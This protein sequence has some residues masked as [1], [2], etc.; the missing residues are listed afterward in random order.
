MFPIKNL[1]KSLLL[2]ILIMNSFFV[3]SSPGFASER[4]SRIHGLLKTQTLTRAPLRA[5]TQPVAKSACIEALT[6]SQLTKSPRHDLTTNPDTVASNNSTDT[7]DLDS[8]LASH[9]ELASLAIE[10]SLLVRIQKA[11]R[12]NPKITSENVP[13]ENML[14]LQDKNEVVYICVLATAFLDKIQGCITLGTD[15]NKPGIKTL[16]VNTDLSHID[17]SEQFLEF[18]E[19]VRD[20]LGSDSMTV[21]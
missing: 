1:L 12:F 18:D 7:S 17:E 19:F 13:T 6:I 4:S 9:L 5:V 21:L 8:K 16:E 2:F 14:L 20:I 11:N 3:L 15:I 10:T